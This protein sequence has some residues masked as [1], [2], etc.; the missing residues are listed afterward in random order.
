VGKPPVIGT[1]TYIAP[2]RLSGHTRRASDQY[3]L[4]IVVYE[5]LCGHPPF[6]GT[7]KEICY[8]QLTVKPAPLYPTYPYVTQE[9]E[10]VVMRAL[11]K[12]PEDRYST[13]QAFAQALEVA[14]LSAL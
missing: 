11:A 5:W 13:V 9:I 12:K 1:A 6:D 3:S 10:D 2:E 7:P 8:K 4:G 14:I